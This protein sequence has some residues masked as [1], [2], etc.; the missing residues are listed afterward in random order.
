[1]VVFVVGYLKIVFL[2][3]GLV[4]N[5]CVIKN[6]RLE[7]MFRGVKENVNNFFE[8]VYGFLYNLKLVYLVLVIFLFGNMK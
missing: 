4:L 1:M 3:C 2:F 8:F 5:Y 7:L 6:K